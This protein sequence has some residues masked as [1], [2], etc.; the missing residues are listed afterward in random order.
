MMSKALAIQH[1]LN[2]VR[3][4]MLV[5]LVLLLSACGFHLRNS[6]SIPNIYK[7]LQVKSSE[8]A[9]LDKWLRAELI[10]MQVQLDGANAP[11]VNILAVRPTRQELVGALTQI[12]IG[13]EVDFRIEDSQGVALTATR[14]IRSYRNFQYNQNTVGIQS[15]QE[16]LLQTELYADAAQQVVRQLATGRMPIMIQ[17][18]S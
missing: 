7:H 3:V 18:T 16:E 9:L 13:L 11:V 5:T 10:G 14:T 6:G 15:Q 4:M 17:S 8:S 12:Q 2:H 1:H